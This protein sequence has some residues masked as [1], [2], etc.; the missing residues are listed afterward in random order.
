MA[1]KKKPTILKAKPPPPVPSPEAFIGNDSATMMAEE[2][3]EE[4]EAR[5]QLA[6]AHAQSSTNTTPALEVDDETRDAPLADD[7][8]ADAEAE[9]DPD[10]APADDDEDFLPPEA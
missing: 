4:F 6:Q 8:V 2:T 3:F 7:D 5:M 9:G 10:D 1:T